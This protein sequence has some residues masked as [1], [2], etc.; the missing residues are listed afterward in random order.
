MNITICL[1]DDVKLIC[2]DYTH[3]PG[4]EP[5]FSGRPDNW[6]SGYPGSIEPLEGYL[7][8]YGEWVPVGAWVLE[9]FE[10]MFL[11]ELKK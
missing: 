6:V 11:A 4:Q 7:E 10:D 2:T 8:V 3:D 9:R 1:G 5:S